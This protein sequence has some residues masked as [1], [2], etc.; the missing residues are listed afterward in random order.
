MWL[1]LKPYLLIYETLLEVLQLLVL[2]MRFTPQFSLVS[3]EPMHFLWPCE[4]FGL[5]QRAARWV[6][7]FQV[8]APVAL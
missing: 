3:P 2:G 7:V 1:L 8:S 5:Q 4:A 6:L